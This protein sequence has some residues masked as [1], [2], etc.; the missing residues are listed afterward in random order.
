MHIKIETSGI[1]HLRKL[2]TALQL[3]RERCQHANI[4]NFFKI[5]TIL[6]NFESEA[7]GSSI[8]ESWTDQQYL[9]LLRYVF[10]QDRAPDIAKQLGKRD[11]DQV[12]SKLQKHLEFVLR[13]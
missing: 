11:R 4:K 5:G 7:N 13:I 9:E 6:K 8:R 10:D 1:R 3:K 2:K 12:H